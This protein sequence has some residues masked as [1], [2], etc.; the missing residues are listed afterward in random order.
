MRVYT[1][2]CGNRVEKGDRTYAVICPCGVYMLE[3]LPR[4]FGDD[5]EKNKSGKSPT[6]ILKDGGVGWVGKDGGKK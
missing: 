3:N 4:N 2:T 1:C 6:I 5:V